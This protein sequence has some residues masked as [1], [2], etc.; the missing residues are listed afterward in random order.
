[1]TARYSRRKTLLEA[2]TFD[3]LTIP[4]ENY[5]TEKL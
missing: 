4:Q 2:Q 3:I 5:G 1:M